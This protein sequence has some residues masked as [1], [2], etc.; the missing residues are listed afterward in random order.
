MINFGG[1]IV[2]WFAVRWPQEKAYWLAFLAGILADLTLGSRLGT[3]AL[4]YSIITF[5]IILFRRRFQYNRFY[6]V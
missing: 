5:L 6:L 3:F 1:I 2:V 4:F